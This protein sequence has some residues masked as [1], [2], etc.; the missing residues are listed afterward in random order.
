M[1]NNK[2]NR[3][4]KSTERRVTAR[5]NIAS[6]TVADF[7]NSFK[8]VKNNFFHVRIEKPKNDIEKALF[9]SIDD[10]KYALERIKST[11]NLYENQ[12]LQLDENEINNAY[13]QIVK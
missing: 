8:N 10:L 3:S 5:R 12:V 9:V 4:Q 7:S 2:N 1:K 13:E 11:D 6:W